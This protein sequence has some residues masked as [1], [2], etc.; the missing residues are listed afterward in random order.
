MIAEYYKQKE[1]F[2]LR[3]PYETIVWV[4]W[5]TRDSKYDQAIKDALRLAIQALDQSD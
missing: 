2:S 3:V 4:S 5:I 1:F